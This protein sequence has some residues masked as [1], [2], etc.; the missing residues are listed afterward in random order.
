MGNFTKTP[1]RYTY[2][3]KSIRTSDLKSFIALFLL[4]WVWVYLFFFWTPVN[5]NKQEKQFSTIQEVLN[6]DGCRVTQDEDEHIKKWQGSM[7][8]VDI[9]CWEAIK[10]FAPK[11]KE[12]YRVKMIWF[13]S[14]MWDYLVLKHW[15]LEYVFWHTKS[16]LKKWEKVLAG[17]EIGIT[18]KSWKSTWYHLHFELWKY[19]YNI[20]YKHL[21]WENAVYN[22]E[23][24]YDLRKQRGWYLWEKEAI[25][26]IAD[27]E[28]F[29]NV[30]YLDWKWRMSIG[31]WTI[32][33]WP[34]DRVTKEEAKQRKM[35]VVEG[36]MESVYRN[37]FVKSHNQRIALVSATYNLWVFSDITKVKYRTTEEWVKNWFSKFVKWSVC[38]SK[39]CVTK[40]LWGLVK[41][42]DLEANLYLKK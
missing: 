29:R 38:D 13:D 25:D 24:T 15:D 5:A 28:W 21:L 6:L 9:S 2:H 27:F 33:K 37:H 42:R 17:Q 36:L 39:W 20:S 30:P 18:N 22:M 3:E 34:K 26:F 1:I 41:R 12:F 7:Y 14:R 23:K 10:I 16:E 35:H 8:A 11:D 40:K 31:Y 19:G 4:L 32:A